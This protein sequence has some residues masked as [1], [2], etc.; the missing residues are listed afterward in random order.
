MVPASSCKL[1]SFNMRIILVSCPEGQIFDVDIQRCQKCPAG[2]YRNKDMTSCS[3]CQ[4]LVSPAGAASCL[5]TC[6]S[7]THQSQ[8]RCIQCPAGTYSDRP[9]LTKCIDCTHD[10]ANTTSFPGAK[11]ASDCGFYSK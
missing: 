2:S 9:G 4:P 1:L 10:K 11:S 7:G 5:A 3:A 8:T 6:P